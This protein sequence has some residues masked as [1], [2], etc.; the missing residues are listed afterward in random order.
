MI[1]YTIKLKFIEYVPSHITSFGIYLPSTL[2]T[3][4]SN[5]FYHSHFYYAINCCLCKKQISVLVFI[6]FYNMRYELVVFP[7][8]SL[9]ISETSNCLLFW[10]I[11]ANL[12]E[13]VNLCFLD[14]SLLS[15]YLILPSSNSFFSA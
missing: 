4:H 9:L 7:K 8:A 15:Q 14:C 1:L 10:K 13:G 2:A 11:C 12:E 5:Y 3:Y 6:Y